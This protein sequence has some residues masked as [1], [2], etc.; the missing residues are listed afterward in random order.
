MSFEERVPNDVFIQK[1]NQ[2]KSI[3]EVSLFFGVSYMTVLRRIK[4]LGC[5]KFT[6]DSKY[7][8][9]EFFAICS[10]SLSMK[11]AA[12][13][14][15]IPFST[16]RRRAERL[17]CYV[18]NPAGI[19]VEKE[20]HSKYSVNED[21]FNIWTPQMAYW[22]G[23]IVADGSIMG[24]RKH[25]FRLRLSSKYK[26]M[27]EY[28]KND[29]QFTGPIL[30]GTTKASKMSGKVYSYSELI[31]NNKN[32]VNSLIKIGV[33]ERKTYQDIEYINYVPDEFKP[34]YLI[35]LFDGDGHIE[36]SSGCIS[37]VGNKVNLFATL[38]YFGFNSDCLY[39]VDKGK[40]IVVIIK[41]RKNSFRFLEIYL[42]CCK[43]LHTLQHKKERIEWFYKVQSQRHP[44]WIKVGDFNNGNCSKY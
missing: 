39:I 12:E 44:E 42:K 25:T 13:Q 22:Y 2:V 10:N 37:F 1:Y 19:G 33:V 21:Y 7:S 8:D 31:I 6:N 5:Q 34:Y 18:P 27:L 23:F 14:M 17:N 9:E 29:V 32:F 26:Y 28:F 15:G 30:E 40:Y 3:K 35:G 20:Y 41:T 38:A 4:K 43:D 36:K 11:Q 24:S 16:F